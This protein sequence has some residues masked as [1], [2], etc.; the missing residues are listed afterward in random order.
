MSPFLNL[1][2]GV[3][4]EEGRKKYMTKETKPAVQSQV[5][6]G[7]AAIAVPFLTDICT[8]L[9]GLPS[10]SLP[11]PIAYGV[12]ALGWF[13]ALYGRFY[14]SNKPISGLVVTPDP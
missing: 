8:Y 4:S 11:A 5:L 13:L 12:T 3:L 10:G 1:P 6:W 2:N 14:G 9:G 7:L